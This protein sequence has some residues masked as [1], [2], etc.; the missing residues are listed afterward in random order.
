MNNNNITNS[1]NNNINNNNNYANLSKYPNI[2]NDKQLKKYKA[3]F[4]KDFEEYQHLHGY[5]HTI[6]EKFKILK[7]L[8]KQSAE[9]S[10]EWESAKEQIFNEYERVK[11]DSN[12]HKARSKYKLLRNKL[13]H[14]KEKI[15]QY[16]RQK[17]VRL[18][19]QNNNI[20]NNN[21]TVNNNKRLKR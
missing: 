5:L 21:S 6:E 15:F 1:N 20:N 4:D 17:R 8:L 10:P 14:I 19:S 16:K 11:G 18:H 9:G 13:A 2:T 12:F 7:E 3:D